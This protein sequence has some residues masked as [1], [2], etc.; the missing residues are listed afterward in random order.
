M[1]QIISDMS[2]VFYFWWNARGREE[3]DVSK[4]ITDL[5]EASNLND[6]V[7]KFEAVNK[8]GG[9]K[10]AVH[11]SGNMADYMFFPKS[12]TN[13]Q[14]HIQNDEM[15]ALGPDI[16]AYIDSLH[17]MDDLNRSLPE[18]EEKWQAEIDKMIEPYR[19]NIAKWLSRNCRFALTNKHA[20]LS[21]EW[22]IDDTGYA[23]FADGDIGDYNHA[24]IAFTSALGINFEENRD[25]PAIE[26]FSSFSPEE[27]E[28]LLENGANPEAVEFLKGGADPRK[29]AMKHMHWIR[30]QGDNFQ[31]WVFDDQALKM[32]RHCNVW[33]S[34][35]DPESLETSDEE[36][37]IEELSTGQYW[38]LPVSV[39]LNMSLNANQVRSWQRV[40]PGVGA[41]VGF[42]A[43]SK[44]I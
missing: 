10:D 7:A 16:D 24:G 38:S 11:H 39:L 43:Y 9:P 14:L 31:T 19:T 3:G 4:A 40:Q 33:D 34:A 23:E 32:I 28:W 8:Q 26:P 27:I 21:G 18:L 44:R 42:S 13:T 35:E 20:L 5:E 36:V 12:E 1:N 2:A 37:A 22:W 29:Y 25:A 15:K 30:V 17:T 41:E 6:P